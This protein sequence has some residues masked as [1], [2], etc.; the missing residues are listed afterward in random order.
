MNNHHFQILTTPQR[1]F[2]LAHTKIFK[3]H[4]LIVPKISLLDHSSKL[5]RIIK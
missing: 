1:T 3:P 4:I 5:L 2:L